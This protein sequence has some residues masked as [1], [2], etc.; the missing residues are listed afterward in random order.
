MKEQRDR[1]QSETGNLGQKDAQGEK[2]KKEDLAHMGEKTQKAE[3][4][5]Q[6]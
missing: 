1:Q 3:K 4:Q 6:K 2:Q 5:Q